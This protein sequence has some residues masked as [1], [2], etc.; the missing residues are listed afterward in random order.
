MGGEISDSEPYP[1]HRFG[2]PPALDHPL[3]ALP[4]LDMVLLVVAVA[5]LGMSS[6]YLGA[7]SCAGL[8][9]V[10]GRIGNGRPDV[11]LLGMLWRVGVS[12]VDFDVETVNSKECNRA[13]GFGG[14]A[15]F[16]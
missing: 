16:P 7:R 1:A 2:L 9:G 11:R 12:L 4:R 14:S 3:T 6:P 8:S 15:M 13:G 5:W 10:D